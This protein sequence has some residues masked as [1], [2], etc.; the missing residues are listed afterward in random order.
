MKITVIYDNNAK[1]GLKSGW[2][3]SCLIESD[4]NILFD[5]G[6]NEKSL[7]YNI[8]KLAIDL[9]TIDMIILSHEHW[10]H[11]GGLADILKSAENV[12]VVL[13]KSF[14]DEMKVA[15]SKHAKIIEITECR[16]LSEDVFSIGELNGHGQPNE[17]AL[18]LK[19]SKGVMVITGC[20][21][22][23]IS[24]ILK[25][26]EKHGKIYGILG[27]FHDFSDFDVLE[28][29]ELLAPCHCT[30]HLKE[31]QDTYPENYRKI[32]AGSVIE[33]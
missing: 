20:A 16:E 24:E 25:E 21:H 7:L 2:G 10:D 13:P 17:Q 23:G 9:K 32:N 27:G 28:G 30:K 26:A 18:A 1:D 22:P 14:S 19:T 29:I 6:D 33:L 12:T 15:I 5:C 8:K 11:T 3:F 4:K 31:I